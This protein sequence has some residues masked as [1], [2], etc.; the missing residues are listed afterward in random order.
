MEGNG[1][2][3]S[4]QIAA[5]R[6]VRFSEMAADLWEHMRDG[7]DPHFMRFQFSHLVD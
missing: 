5:P 3:A 2:A 7:S 1:A 6:C 4:L